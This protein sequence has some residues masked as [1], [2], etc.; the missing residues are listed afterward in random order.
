MR[1][2]LLL[3]P[4]VGVNSFTMISNAATLL[5]NL[6]GILGV[7]GGFASAFAIVE[8]NK[9][10]V[11][12]SKFFRRR[13]K[14]KPIDD[15]KERGKYTEKIVLENDDIDG[16]DVIENVEEYFQQ[17]G[18]DKAVA[19]ATSA[20]VAPEPAPAPAE[21]APEAAALAQEAEHSRARGA[22]A[23]AEPPPGAV[24]VAV[25]E[26]P[27]AEP[28]AAPAAAPSTHAPAAAAPAAAPS[29]Q[30]PA[31]PPMLQGSP[32]PES[33]EDWVNGVGAQ[34]REPKALRSPRP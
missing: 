10:F 23:L 16:P 1:V 29:P 13:L 6:V 12:L 15:P 8:K 26:P 22:L 18:Q 17:S 24:A 19:G 14:L 7:I 31:A 3:L 20:K 11:R 34:L 4:F 2:N 33:I 27:G 28:A 25:A 5:A 30:A 32:P 9:Y 21:A